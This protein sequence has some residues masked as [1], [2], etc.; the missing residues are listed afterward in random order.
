MGRT[1]DH[2]ICP[3]CKYNFQNVGSIDGDV[4]CKECGV[5]M[6]IWMCDEWSGGCTCPIKREVKDDDT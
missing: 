1:V 3:E 6:E 2:Y 5:V 4:E